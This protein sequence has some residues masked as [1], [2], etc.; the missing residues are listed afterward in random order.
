ML[1]RH[2]HLAM[3]VIFLFNILPNAKF[4]L[5][6]RDYQGN[7]ALITVY[8]SGHRF[9]ENLSDSL[10]SHKQPCLFVL[11]RKEINSRFCINK[12]ASCMIYA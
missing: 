10:Q 7:R 12:S 6:T 4:P 11:K 8:F 1:S 5:E 3:H 2:E 9:D